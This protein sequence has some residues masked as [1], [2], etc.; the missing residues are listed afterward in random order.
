MSVFA[1]GVNSLSR[2]SR[3]LI[4]VSDL[5]LGRG[6][7]KVTKRYHRLEAFFYDEDFRAF[8]RWACG[9]AA[10]R[11]RPLTLILDGDV[12]DLLRIEP[13]TTG[14]GKG[15]ERRFGPLATPPVA[16]QM[17]ADVL[18]GHPV[19]V[20]ALA[21]VLAAGHQVV[22]VCGNHD[23]ELQWQEVQHEV[24]RALHSV[25]RERRA[26]DALGGLR[27]EAWF[28]HE[29]G[30]I[31]VEH[32]CQYDPENAFQFHLRS[33]LAGSPFVAQV[34]ERDMPL[35]NFFQRYLYNAF[36]SLTFIVPSSRANY[37]YFRF[38]LANN[39]RLLLRVARSQG[40]F[41]VQLLRRLAGSSEAS[42]SRAAEVAHAAE[43][44]DLAE[45]SGLGE[46]LCAI[47]EIKCRG[48]DAARAASGML[49][50][51]AKLASGAILSSVLA[52]AILTA[53]SH[54]IEALTVGFGWKALLSLG[55]YLT[56]GALTASALVAAA[57]RVPG[58]EPPR[59]LRAAAQHIAV[60]L[61]VPLVVFGHTHDEV[62]SRLVLPG[63]RCGWYFNTGTWLA[64][65]THDVLVPR[66]RVQYTFLRVRGH[67]AELLHWSPGRG[68]EMPV[69]L[70]EEQEDSV[71]YP[72]PLEHAV[73]S[74]VESEPRVTK[75][76]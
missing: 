23:L 16:A 18:A 5:H 28:Y 47:D 7:D 41:L 44:E 71:A 32:G 9:D 60:L 49:K 21:D 46:R 31:W 62:V 54:A 75:T 68:R 26:A 8:C 24:R 6:L 10:S 61:D 57:V 19:V 74:P 29:P 40:R 20:E 50:Q 15:L 35:G 36:G 70:L 12:F 25:L 17:V 34:I 11:G 43:L 52:L 51:A 1:P 58:D 45:R 22:L 73:A 42:W 72:L 38:L 65:F 2:P 13:S 53:A 14:E 27:F 3:D 67:E 39:P 64:V 33:R 55:L 48:A 56:F 66:E 30:R 63:G 37:R 76:A 59:P 69:V 4:I